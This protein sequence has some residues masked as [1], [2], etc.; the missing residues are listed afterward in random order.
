MHSYKYNYSSLEESQVY[1]PN[2][3]NILNIMG[4]KCIITDFAILL[5]G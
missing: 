5:G 2:K 1:G 4:T 3:L